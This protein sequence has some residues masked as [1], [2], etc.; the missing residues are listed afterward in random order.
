MAVSAD[1]VARGFIA[2][3]GQPGRNMTGLSS[4]GADLSG[5]QLEII[6]ETVPMPWWH[7]EPIL[8]SKERDWKPSTYSRRACPRPYLWGGRRGTGAFT[9][10]PTASSGG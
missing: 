3:L 7:C 10:K 4:L 1:P 5:K 2:N 8:K 6:K 9:R